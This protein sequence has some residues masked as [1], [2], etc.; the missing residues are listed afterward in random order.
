[1][2][3]VSDG[4]V[5]PKGLIYFNEHGILSGYIEE[6]GPTFYCASIGGEMEYRH[7]DEGLHELEDLVY[8][9]LLL[10]TE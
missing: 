5:T 4:E 1:M 10:P 9:Q 6:M 3:G 8:Q 2:L 7:G